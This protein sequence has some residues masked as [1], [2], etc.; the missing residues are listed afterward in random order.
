M[1]DTPCIFVRLIFGIYRESFGINTTVLS[2]V[3]ISTARVRQFN[4][5]EKPNE[6]VSAR[7]QVSVVNT[8]YS[9]LS[10]NRHARNPVHPRN[11]GEEGRK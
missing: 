5:S 10:D 3:K 11:N 2:K 1:F 4:K 6:I 9:L 8:R 7:G